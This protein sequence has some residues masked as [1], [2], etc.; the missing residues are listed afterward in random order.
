MDRFAIGTVNDELVASAISL[1]VK[2]ALPSADCLQ[3]ISALEF[4]KA[5][6]EAKE[7]LVLVSSDK[8]LCKA[9]QNEGVVYIDPEEEDALDKLSSIVQR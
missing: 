6:E 7:K 3:L 8:D 9:S 5:L 1:A 4:K 2:H